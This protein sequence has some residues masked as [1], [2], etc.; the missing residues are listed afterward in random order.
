[1]AR[2]LRCCD[3]G[4]SSSD[5]TPSLGTCICCGSDPRKKAKRQ[6]IK[7]KVTTDYNP[8]NCK[9]TTILALCVIHINSLIFPL[10][11]VCAVIK[12][13]LPETFKVCYYHIFEIAGILCVRYYK[14]HFSLQLYFFACLQHDRVVT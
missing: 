9:N 5:W 11:L 8:K 2:I 12:Y 14:C 10:A 13:Q 3:S 1:M 4:S 6:K 7:K